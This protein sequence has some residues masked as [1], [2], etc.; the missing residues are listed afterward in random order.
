MSSLFYFFKESLQG[1]ARNL[2]TTLGSIITIFLS[3]LIIGVFLVGGTIVERLVSS[4]EDEV[5]IT[6]Y[7]ADDAPQESIDAVTA[8]IQGMD[9]VESVG[10]TTKEQA[11]ENFSN[12]MT[13][14]PE[15]I[16]QLDGTNPLPAS[17]DV[18]LAD[19]QKVDEI[20]AAIE[21]DY[22]TQ[23]FTLIQKL[24][25]FAG[26]LAL[27]LTYSLPLTL[28]A[29]VL[30]M[31]PFAVSM[32]A[33]N[34]LSDAACRVSDRNR[35]FTAFLSDYLNGFP[36]IR[37]FRAED[38][39]NQ[40]FA[41]ENHR[42]EQQKCT[43]LKLQTLLESAGSFTGI[44]A[45]LGIFLLGTWLALTG[46]GVT[47]G[48]VIAFVNLM[49]FIIE[50]IAALP[51]LLAARKAAL[52]LVQK[53]ADSLAGQT[54]QPG[55]QPLPRLMQQIELEHAGYRYTPGK[56]VLQ[57]LSATLKAGKAY[58][59]V[60]ASGG[61]K[62][63]LL[64]LLH[65]PDDN[66]SGQVLFDGIDIRRLTPESLN[67]LVS[68]V[69]QNVFV[70]NASIRD[71]IT[72]F[73]AFPQETLDEVIRRAHL[74]EL[75]ARRGLD[76][77]CG[78]GGCEL[79]GGEKQRIAIARALLKQSSILL[80]DE[81]TAAL[82]AQTAH[83]ITQD[84]LSLTGITRVVVTHRLEASLLECYDE[85]FVLKDGRIAETGTFAELVQH[86]GYFSAM[87]KLAH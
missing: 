8:M 43:R 68:V 41:S 34:R 81:A 39:I 25:C 86:G 9:G 27:M 56:P 67:G 54:A 51:S 87:Y 37:S 72:M 82:D 63:T 47:P 15:I 58:A 3:L 30:S 19:P 10:F 61:G 71:N 35:D 23:Q 64:R 45:Q 50:P 48:V 33:G 83:E 13:T 85:I 16:E 26:A 2:S 1:F 52:A 77:L 40:R 66:T 59:V 75:V 14:N 6:A 11:L 84:I 38:E 79:S 49:N 24:F 36:V 65:I 70:F 69:Q 17:I 44:T 46:R 5:S 42:L 31:L 12:S 18:S 29:I 20:A 80:A 7:V 4:I 53:L 73:R 57:D 62:S 60:G 28:A 76:A 74:E 55:G 32:V 22:L 21:A 78:E